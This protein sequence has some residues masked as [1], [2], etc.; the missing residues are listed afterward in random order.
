M[1]HDDE[2]FG[3]MEAASAAADAMG[4][5]PASLFDFLADAQRGGI[6]PYKS[7]VEL[8]SAEAVRLRAWIQGCGLLAQRGA[9]VDWL[10]GQA[11]LWLCEMRGARELGQ[12]DQAVLRARLAESAA[13]LLART[14]AAPDPRVALDEIERWR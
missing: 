12:P 11:L 6:V 2:I 5:S 3:L 14:L 8:T 1:L 9:D 4:C 13:A 10:S 7:L